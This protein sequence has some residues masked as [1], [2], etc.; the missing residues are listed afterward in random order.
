MQTKHDQIYT[1]HLDTR[2]EMD[3]IR[4]LWAESVVDWNAQTRTVRVE[5]DPLAMD[6]FL[7]FYDLYQYLE[8][9][10]QPALHRDEDAPRFGAVG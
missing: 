1:F 7:L 5:T 8:A 3:D 9:N 6:Q 4:E 2:E 10:P